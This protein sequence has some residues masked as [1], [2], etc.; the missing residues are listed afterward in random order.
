MALSLD[1]IHTTNR[2]G[3]LASFWGFTG[4]IAILVIALIK[5]TAIAIDSFNY[6]FSALHWLALIVNSVFMAYSEGYKGFQKG[7]SPR[8][9]ARLNYLHHHANLLTTLLAPLFCMGFFAAPNKRIITSVLLTVM[10]VLFILFFQLI[11]QPWRGILDIGVV[12]GLSWGLIATVF[13]CYQAF[14]NPATCVDAE[15]V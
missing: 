7:Y 11:P 9:A 12:I 2:L 15:V 6:S 5:L 4:F 8:L 14:I 10:I 1:H 3:W 13:F